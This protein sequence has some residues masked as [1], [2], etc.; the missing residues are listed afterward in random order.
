MKEVR[1]Y[2]IRVCF[3]GS[4]TKVR[5]GRKYVTGYWRVKF[6]VRG[7]KVMVRVRASRI[8]NTVRVRF[9]ASQRP[10]PLV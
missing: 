4:W 2:S 5:H 8:K 7:I 10:F 1:V 9:W 6:M 3:R